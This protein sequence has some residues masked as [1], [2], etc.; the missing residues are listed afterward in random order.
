MALS[1]RHLSQ[2]ELAIL[3]ALAEGW[4]SRE[5]ATFVRRSKSTVDGYVQRL[6]LKFEARS[7][8]QLVAKAFCCGT[9]GRDL[10]DGPV[11]MQRMLGD[12]WSSDSTTAVGQED[13][14]SR[15]RGPVPLRVPA[16]R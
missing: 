8:I 14:L 3:R 16:R 12:G 9:L 10:H 7:R 13:D 1:R 5:I 11:E 15:Q 2:M 4:H 6:C